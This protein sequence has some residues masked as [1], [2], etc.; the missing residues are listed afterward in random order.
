MSKKLEKSCYIQDCSPTHN[1]FI[2]HIA[3]CVLLLLLTA[4][5][6]DVSVSNYTSVA[7]LSEIE[8]STFENITSENSTFTNTVKN[9]S[10]VILHNLEETGFHLYNAVAFKSKKEGMIVGGAGL[11]VRTTKDA[12]LHWR[13]DKFSSFVNP[14]HSL[15]F[16]KDDVFVVGES[17][18][19]FRSSDF[20]EGWEVLD[21][22][23]LL[24]S[25]EY[26]RNF[27]KY[28]K[29]KFYMNDL[30]LIVGGDNGKAIILKTLNGGKI[31]KN[32]DLEGLL[33]NEGGITDVKILSEKTI[34]TVTSLGRCY[35]S[36]DG[37]NNWTLIYDDQTKPLN[38]IDFNNEDDG[39]I[40]GIGGA[41]LHTQ[42]GGSTWDTISF[43]S[44]QSAINVSNVEY[45]NSDS[46][47]VTTAISFQDKERD[48]LYKIDT[49]TQSAEV[50]LSKGEDNSAVRFVGESFG[51]QIL[52]DSLF[53]LDRNNLYQMNLE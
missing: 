53:V 31:W 35:K 25:Q 9:N 4:C 29:I 5:S 39:Y 36:V 17:K 48:F 37:G 8:A 28:Y 11:R 15:A 47:V 2:S 34:I 23:P 50:F 12:G 14:F 43:S 24:D 40:G 26:A 27:P 19:I 45:L 32:L 22:Q 10:V 16:N 52:D 49:N 6:N 20:G 44:D 38:A 51:L 30:G 41:L 13:E 21:T 18:Y 33:E 3:A 7:D 46:I 1:F 42:D